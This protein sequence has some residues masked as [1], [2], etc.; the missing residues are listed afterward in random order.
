MSKNDSLHKISRLLQ[1]AQRANKLAIGAFAVE[2]IAK[3][4]KAHMFVFA[5]D[6]S[7]KSVD[8]I[9]RLAPNCP[10]ISIASKSE[11]GALLGRGDVALIGVQDENF[12]EGILNYSNQ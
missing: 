5:G 9:R 3:Q 10:H 11:L 1:L 6:A 7:P 2:S 8:N 12:A 4:G